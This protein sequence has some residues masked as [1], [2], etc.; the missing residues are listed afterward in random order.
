MIKSMRASG[1]SITYNITISIAKGL[2]KAHDRTLLKEH[3]GSIDLY[4][5]WVQ[6][7]HRSLG[8]VKRKATIS[9]QPVSPGFIHEA[10]FTFYSAIQG[11]INAYLIP[12]E[13]VINTD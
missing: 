8:Y 9:K 7:I 5:T 6:S 3:G 11:N 4:Q 10:G 2:V 13:L 1:Y 12:P